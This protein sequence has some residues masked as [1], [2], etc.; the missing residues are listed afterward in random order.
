MHEPGCPESAAAWILRDPE[1]APRPDTLPPGGSWE[2][3]ATPAALGAGSGG[4][5]RTVSL[6]CLVFDPAAPR[7]ALRLWVQAGTER[8]AYTFWY[9]LM[10]PP[11]ED[12]AVAAGRAEDAG[13]GVR[14]GGTL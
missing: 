7:T 13:N 8:Y 14:A 6:P 10:E 12:A 9:R 2:A 1:G 4:V 5:W 11:P 3:V